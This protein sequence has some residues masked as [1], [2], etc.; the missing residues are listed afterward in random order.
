M[1]IGH[2]S[3]RVSLFGGG[4]DYPAR[5]QKHG[6]SVMGLAINTY[7]YITLRTL[8][9]FFADRHRLVYSKVELVDDIAEFQH[10]VVRPVLSEIGI[11]RDRGTSQGVEIH[12]D[13][14]LPARSGMG[15]SSAF[16]VG[17]I[18]VLL[19]RQGRMASRQHL[20]AEAIRVDTSGSKIVVYESDG[21]ENR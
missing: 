16:T 2:T 13:D 5:Y 17:L 9:P 8:P 15:S 21:L 11:D 18:H 4:S 7:C 20:A 6:G 1:I 10:P 14:D 12:H 19:A 3:F